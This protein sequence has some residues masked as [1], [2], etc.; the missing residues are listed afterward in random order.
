MGICGSKSTKK[1]EKQKVEIKIGGGDN[2]V[3]KWII[4]KGIPQPEAHVIKGW[5]MKF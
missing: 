5:E 1:A 4:V 2:G 3:C